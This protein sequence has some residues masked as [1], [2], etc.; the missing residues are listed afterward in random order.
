[1]ADSS[2]ITAQRLREVLS[3][4]P[5]T[6]VF[7]WAKMIGQRCSVG[8][9]AGILYRDRRPRR[10]IAIDGRRYPEHNLAWLY[11][12]GE[13]PTHEIDHINNDATDNRWTNLRP[14]TR[15]QNNQNTRRR[16]DN[17]TG[18]KGVN[19]HEGRYAARI[20]VNK[21]R[22]FLGHFDTPEEAYAARC[23]AAQEYHGEFSNPG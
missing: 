19:L 7:T 3:Y 10:S 15:A 1:M 9:R 12:T 2:I 21:K 4:D 20:Q 22:I 5:E 23:K 6:G 16:L 8:T 18:Y 13:F 17:T 14:A 11:M